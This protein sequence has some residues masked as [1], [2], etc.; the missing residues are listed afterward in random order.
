MD[1]SRRTF[2][3]KSALGATTLAFGLNAASYARII[4]ANDRVN[5][6]IA[7]INS[8]GKAL[9]AAALD[10]ENCTVTHLCDVDSRVL[11]TV[12]ASVKESTGK[13]PKTY[14]DIRKLLESKDVDALAIATPDHWHAPMAIMGVQ[15][16]K[17][18]YVEKPCCYDP[19]EGELLVEVQK[20]YGKV[21]QMGNQQ[22]SGLISIQAI[23]DIH[24]GIIGDVYMGKA[25]YSNNRGSIG[26]GK[27]AEVPDWLNWDL[28]QGPAPRVGYKDNVVHY[29]WHWFHRW[30]TGEINNNGTHEID[31]C[32][33]ALDV[34]Y[35]IRVSSAGGRYHFEDDW[36]FPDTQVANFEFE[37]GKLI[38][39]EGKSCNVHPYF[40]RGRGVTIH[41]TEGTVL[42]DRNSYLVYDN[43]NN[44][45][46][47]MNEKDASA[48]MN[49]VGAGSLDTKHMANFVNAFRE[50]EKQNSPILEGYKSNLLCHLGNIAQE[51]G[52]VLDTSSSN[53]HILNNNEANAY[54][55]RDYA[56]GWVPTL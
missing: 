41:G 26:V 37:G 52:S 49:T 23:K 51:T 35:P 28:W 32:R 19:G 24:S 1:K 17:H 42:L 7:G 21:V 36:Q 8:R 56:E 10:V 45:I 6:A 12:K 13:A 5:F 39:W 40:D 53:G 33:W 31:I 29:N 11:A 43:K 3:K 34:D 48:T 15:A 14:D 27:L 54:W 4:G 46:K 50:A 20:K 22:R 9:T 18:V 44:L 47:E 25:W 2:I 55:N 16:G 30:G 38:T